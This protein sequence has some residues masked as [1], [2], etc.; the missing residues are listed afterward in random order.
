MT[1]RR[2]R[3]LRVGRA[4]RRGRRGVGAVAS[5]CTLV[6]AAGLAS[7]GGDPAGPVSVEE[8]ASWCAESSL[9]AY[10]RSQNRQGSINRPG[11]DE[12]IAETLQ[13]LVENYESIVPPAELAD[14]HDG[15]LG[16]V[17]AAA[18]AFDAVPP[19]EDVSSPE[20]FEELVQRVESRYYVEGVL[21]DVA[22]D[23]QDASNRLALPPHVRESLTAS[24]C[25]PL[26]EPAQ[27][28]Y[29]R[30]GSAIVVSWEPVLGA[31]SYAVYHD[32]EVSDPDCRVESDGTVG[33]CDELN[34]FVIIARYVH[35]SP[36]AGENHYWVSACND[37]HCTAIDVGSGQHATKLPSP[38]ARSAGASPTTELPGE[39]SEL[40]ASR[41]TLPFA[42]AI[43]MCGG[44]VEALKVAHVEACAT[45]DAGL[46]WR[47]YADFARDSAIEARARAV[48]DEH[49]AAYF[50]ALAAHYANEAER[51]ENFAREETTY[52]SERRA[53]II[54]ARGVASWTEACLQMTD[55]LWRLDLHSLAS[56]D[57]DL[58]AHFGELGDD[59]CYS[60]VGFLCVGI[61]ILEVGI[62]TFAGLFEALGLGMEALGLG[63]E[64]LGTGL[65]AFGAVVEGIFGIF[66]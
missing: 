14:F 16:R 27:V 29:E 51:A 23:L 18:V 25:L 35:V 56:V 55:E 46:G 44:D 45:D 39:C 9:L 48:G 61:D 57:D 63:M 40:W 3:F 42:A 30:A 22:R 66:G 36:A 11:D 65:E 21:W 50:E 60:I 5:A 38:A 58:A 53:R 1:V 59:V 20:N 52:E 4:T 49:I 10:A 13:V 54:A 41:P 24:G 19:P 64:V 33:F 28:Q 7:C 2:A 15:A 32:D 62:D 43:S 6:V 34:P 17:R 47:A 12:A 37:W 26:S 8:Y 31:D